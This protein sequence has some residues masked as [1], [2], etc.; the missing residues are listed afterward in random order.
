MTIAQAILNMVKKGGNLNFSYDV[1]SRSLLIRRW[2]RWS[3]EMKE[4]L[5]V[6]I[7]EL[8]IQT[9]NKDYELFRVLERLDS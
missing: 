2:Y 1:G 8:Q 7:S 9:E 5:N 6:N 3:N 4:E